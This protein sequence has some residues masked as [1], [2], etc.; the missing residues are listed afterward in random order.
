[1]IQWGFF[2]FM[3][4]KRYFAPTEK[5]KNENQDYIARPKFLNI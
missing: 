3:K 5:A 2:P 1:M 4:G